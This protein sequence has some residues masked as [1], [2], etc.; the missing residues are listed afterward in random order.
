MAVLFALDRAAPRIGSAELLVRHDIVLLD[1]YVASNAAYTAARLHQGADGEWS[2]GSVQLEFDR[3]ALP[4]ARRAAASRRTRGAR[5]ASAPGI[6]R[7]A[8]DTSRSATPTSATAVCRRRTGAVYARLAATAV[9]VAGGRRRD[10]PAR[11]HCDRAIGLAA[12]S[13]L[14]EAVTRT[15]HGSDTDRRT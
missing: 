9:G 15:P 6:A 8:D 14:N 13:L 5:R 2:S 10:G 7:E 11:T 3:L 12:D 4:D 1:R